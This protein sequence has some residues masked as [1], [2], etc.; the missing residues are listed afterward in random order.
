MPEPEPEAWLVRHGET[1]WSASARHTGRTDV[2]LTP[3][4]ED[5]ARALR[6]SLGRV[7]F[8]LVLC[9]PRQRALRT[10][11][12]AGLGPVQVDAD[13]AEWDY[14]DYEGLTSLEIQ[15]TQ[16]GWTIWDGPWPGG[17]SGADVAARADR[18]IGRVRASGAGRVALVGHGHFSRV[19]AARWVGAE[20]ETGR[21]L[22]L[23]VACWSRL[24]WDRGV[25][26]VGNWNV[27]SGPPA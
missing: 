13:L 10:A 25:A 15:A 14:G 17:E 18:L 6:A 4:G 23:D 2:E 8:D 27:P 9:S 11:E 21:W 26:V 24:A 5:Q 22:T 1:E 19:V 3:A 12:L 7:E 16:P 20:V